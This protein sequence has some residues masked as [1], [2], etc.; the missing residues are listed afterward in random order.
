M[1]WILL[2]ISVMDH[3]QM[4]IAVGQMAERRVKCIARFVVIL[5]WCFNVLTFAR[6]I[7]GL[8]VEASPIS[9]N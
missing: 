9:T 2:M 4:M 3:H 5:T 6:Q 1:Y 8:L 7:F